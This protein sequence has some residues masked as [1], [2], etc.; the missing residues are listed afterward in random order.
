MVIIVFSVIWEV[1]IV[2]FISNAFYITMK[3]HYAS[4]TNIFQ[5]DGLQWF[6][7]CMEQLSKWVTIYLQNR[8]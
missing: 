2:Q 8:E 3:A 5:I 1:S 6:R 7:D 4:S